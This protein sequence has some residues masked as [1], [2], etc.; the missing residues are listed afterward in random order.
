MSRQYRVWME[1]LTRCINDCMPLEE[2]YVLLHSANLIGLFTCVFVKH[3]E[4]QR[5]KNIGAS[6]I[7]RGM[8]GLHGNKVGSSYSGCRQLLIADCCRVHLYCALSSMTAPSALLTATWQ[9][10]R[11]RPHTATMISRRFSRRSRFLRR[12]VSQLA[13]TTT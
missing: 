3:K 1:H 7:K 6:E 11:R 2:S 10:V 12:L 13:R 9:L 4:R 8:G 5:I